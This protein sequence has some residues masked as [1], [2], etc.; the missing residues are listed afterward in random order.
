MKV[1]KLLLK[2]PI[3]TELISNL[4]TNACPLPFKANHK[5]DL[6]ISQGSLF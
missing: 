4:P 5:R 2:Y 1:F 6:G 3:K